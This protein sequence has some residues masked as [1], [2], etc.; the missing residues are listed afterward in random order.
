MQIRHLLFRHLSLFIFIF[1]EKYLIS[2]RGWFLVGSVEV[3]VKCADLKTTFSE[4]SRAHLLPVFHVRFFKNWDNPFLF[5]IYFCLFKHTIQT[6][7]LKGL[8]KCPS[9]IWCWNSNSQPLEHQSPLI[10]TRLGVRFLPF[11]VEEL[12]GVVGVTEAEASFDPHAE[13]T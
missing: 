5:L 1:I 11:L 9:S 12:D 7:Q 4:W 13:L 3:E 6:L 8:Q 10:T 2:L